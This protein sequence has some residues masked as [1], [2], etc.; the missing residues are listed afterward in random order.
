MKIGPILGALAFVALAAGAGADEASD[1]VRAQKLQADGNFKEA[2]AVFQKL[3]SEPRSAAGKVPD[4]LERGLDCLQRLGGQAQMDGFIEQAV[5]AHAKNWRL[6]EQAAL[7]VMNQL[8]HHGMMVGGEFQRGNHRGGVGGRWV[9]VAERDRV[10]ALQLM[11]QALPLVQAQRPVAETYGFYFNY[12]SLVLGQRGGDGAWRLQALTDLGS[13]PDYEEPLAGGSQGGAPVDA[14]GQ[15]VYYGVPESFAQAASDGERWRWLLRQAETVSPAM[16]AHPRLAFARFLQEQFDVQTMASFR[17]WFR[18]DSAEERAGVFAVQ[19]LKDNETIA[20]LATGVKRFTLPPEFCFIARFKELANQEGDDTGLNREATQTLANLYENRRQYP[21]AVTWWERFAAFEPDAAQQRIRQITGNW[22]QFEPQRAQPAGQPA[23]VPF[24]F[25]NAPQVSFTAYR[26]DL[27]RLMEDARVYLRSK[28]ERLDGQKLNLYDLGQRLVWENQEQYLTGKVTEWELKLDPKPDHFDRLITV[29]TP[30]KDAGAYLLVGQLPAGN[31]SRILIVLDSTVIVHKPLDKQHLILT[32]DAVSGQ[33]LPNLKVE[34]F[35]YRQEWI[36][37]TRKHR[38]IT[39]EASAQTDADG[40]LILSP[41]RA[42]EGFQWLITASAPGRFAYD[43]FIGI[44]YPEHYDGDYEAT[45]SFVITDRPVYRPG[46]KVQWKAWVAHTKYDIDDQNA[47]AG[48]PLTIIINNPRGEAIFDQALTAD[49]YGGV[50]GEL[51]LADEC[52]LGGYAL[53]VNVGDLYVGYY[54]FQVEEYKKPEFEVTVQAPT[55]PVALGEKIEAKVEAKYY[56]GGPVTKATAKIKV[57]RYEHQ[58]TWYPVMPWDWFYGPG[59][60]WFAYDY[61]WYPGWQRWG[62]QRPAYWWAQAPGGPPE[63]VADVELPLNADGSATLTLDTAV[64]KEVMGDRDHRYEITAEVRDESR[65]TIVGN[66]SVIAA[67]EPFKVYAWVDRGHYAVGDTVQASFQARTPDGK[68]VAG[69]GR[70]RLLRLTYDAARAPVEKEVQAWDLATDDQGGATQVLTASAPGQFR[71]AYAVTDA[72]NHTLEGGYVFSVRGEGAKPGDFRFS[73]I[74]LVPDKAEYRPG[75]R[76][77]LAVRADRE[78]A[79]VL[80]FVRAANGICLPPK[81]IRLKG[82]SAIEEIDIT[83]K[84]MPNVFIEAVTVADGEVYTAIKEIVVPPEQRVLGVEVLPSATRFAPGAK[85]QVKIKLTEAGGAPFVGTVVV[86]VYDKSVEYVAGGSNVGDIR[87]NFWQWRRQHS[88][89]TLH[90]LA[91]WFNNLLKPRETPMQAVGVFVHADEGD[92]ANGAGLGF[93]GTGG[94]PRRRGGGMMVKGMLG[95]AP[96]MGGEMAMD[97]VAMTAAAPMAGGAMEP[98][99]GMQGP[100]MMMAARDAG[101]GAAGGMGGG[102]PA[103]VQPVVRKEFA[104]TALW[105]ATL[106]TEADGTATIPLP[107]PENLT[108]WK[109]RVWAMGKG[110]RVGAGSAEVI[111]SKNLLLRLQAPRFFVQKDEVVLSANVHN[112]LETDKEVRAV[113]ELSGPCLE[114]D[115]KPER[116]I[117]IAAKGEARVDWRVKVVREGEAVVRMKALS[118]AESDAME[119]RFPVY[120]HGMD[121]LV[122]SCGL[123]RNQDTRAEITIEVPKQR[124]PESARLELRFSPSLAMAMVDALPYLADFPYGCTE[125]TLNR[126]LP[127]VITQNVLQRMGISLKDIRDKHTN[128]N[129][130]ELGDAA[131]RATQWQRNKLAPVFDEKVVASLVRDG[132]GTLLAMQLSDGG[133]G[134]FSGWGERSSAH[135]TATVVHGLQVAVQNDVAVAPEVI[136]NGIEWLRRYQSEQV[137]LLQNAE[138]DPRPELWKAKADATDALVYRVLGDAEVADEAMREFLYRDRAELSLYGLSLYGLALQRQKQDEKLGMVL[139]NLAQ[140]VVRDEENQTAY[141]NLGTGNAWWYWYGSEIEAQATYLKLLCA[142]DPRNDLLPRLV[143]YLLNNRKHATYWN[144]TRDTALCVEAFADYI[145]AAGEDRPEMTVTL[146]LDGQPCKKVVIKPEDLFTFDN[147]FVLAGELVET[148]RH[149][150]VLTRE[151]KGPLYW[152]CYV[153]YFT[154]EDPITKAGLEVKS[155]RA[156]FRLVPNDRTVAVAGA[157]GQV[158]SQRAEHYRREPLASGA[159]VDSG[160]LIEVELTV[161]SKND[162]EY[163]VLEDFKAAGCEPVDLRSGYTGNELGAYVEFRD[164]RTAFFMRQL[165]R[166]KHSVSYRLRA[167]VPGTFSAL[168]AKIWAMYAP[169]LRG[170]SDENKLEIGERK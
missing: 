96:G 119:M 90:T 36:E 34:L 29:T 30:L 150:L 31:T 62:C 147:A 84:D 92:E 106:E 105:V 38:L 2:Y 126:F 73:H 130:Q 152:N 64:A 89:N 85:G 137:R 122:S 117:H 19:T 81:C 24:R 69:A 48:Q 127:T 67:R 151:G 160:D 44:G 107:M 91:R 124:R 71:L 87:A 136:Q 86:S 169:E 123:L 134:W 146:S 5:K 20:R 68:G 50:S 79:F 133:W 131:Q 140:F 40:L 157:R 23:T 99:G 141:L 129:A 135:T 148:G 17:S 56:F 100:A 167:E 118:D 12:A 53:A 102:G 65:R 35:G 43:G 114:I 158:L 145:K 75:E 18:T 4:D 46:Q 61:D 166:G 7:N 66:G 13:L 11:Q 113:L 16:A 128:L 49:A 115:G 72:A 104:D 125:Q 32:A 97:S 39:T 159:R 95:P 132:V 6:L 21:E 121:K 41:E 45:K 57:L 42:P 37:K 170:N 33:P 14:E 55:E 25:R 120:V 74:E 22:G 142:A 98:G 52:P 15:P 82:R 76:M 101:P 165:A 8:P 161:E 153:S 116:K 154:L 10:W 9:Q 155:E 60:G 110:T 138:R 78:D 162:Y 51:P 59:Y 111:T 27:P 63:V 26:V 77:E 80:L 164:E 109:I 93:G 103:L 149:T 58:T 83:Q 70:L 156:L 108:T 163:I 88:E 112:Y 54:S 168:P 144:S 47:F 28:P 1:R 139:R 143:K 94:M 3:V